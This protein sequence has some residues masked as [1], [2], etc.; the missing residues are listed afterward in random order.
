MDGIHRPADTARPGCSSL[1]A[2]GP[3]DRLE[4]RRRHRARGDRH[5]HQAD[6]NLEKSGRHARRPLGAL[7]RI[8]VSPARSHKASQLVR[9]STSKQSKPRH[10]HG[11]RWGRVVD[12]GALLEAAGLEGWLSTVVVP[13]FLSPET[14]PNS[15]GWLT[16]TR[17]PA[18]PRQVQSLSSHWPRS[19]LVSPSLSPSGLLLLSSLLSAAS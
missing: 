1:G 13:L 15:C 10:R 16:P 19:P 2:V 14:N 5:R 11:S 9:T 7:G 18:S 4:Q 6:T 8:L 3:P 12:V 17:C